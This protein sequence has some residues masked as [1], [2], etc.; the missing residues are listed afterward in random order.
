MGLLGAGALVR[1]KAINLKCYFVIV[2]EGK[3]GIGE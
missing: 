2:V 1:K 3:S